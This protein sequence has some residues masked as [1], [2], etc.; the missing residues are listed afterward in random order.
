MCAVPAAEVAEL[1]ELSAA[2]DRL[3]ARGPARLGDAETVVE[4]HRQHARLDAVLAGVTAEF[5]ATE[6][7]ALDGARTPTMWLA[8]RCRI[9]KAVAKRR[10]R[11][12]SRIRKLEA[13]ARAWL[14]GDVTESHVSVID[15]IANRRTDDALARDEETLLEQAKGLRFDHF[16]KALNYWAQLADPDGTEDEAEAQRN[17]RDAYL[18][19]SFDGMFLGKLN[20]DPIS[21]AI[22]SNEWNRLVDELYES[23]HNAAK[24]R[25]GRNPGFHELA[26]DAAQRR[27]DALVE[28]AMRSAMVTGGARP[29]PLFTVLVDYETLSGRVCEL[30]QGVVV[31]PGTVVPWLEVADIERAVFGPARRVEIGQRARL[32]RGATRRS[33]ELRDGEC[34]HPFCDRPAQECEC[35]HIL[36]YAE[37]GETTQ[38]NGR[39]LCRP[40]NRMRNNL[41]P[42]RDD[43]NSAPKAGEP[44]KPRK[45]KKRDLGQTSQPEQ[46]PQP[47]WRRQQRPPPPTP[48]PSLPPAA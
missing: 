22:V 47:G 24:E 33:V 2:I 39:M 37:G 34:Q 17:R 32:F 12:G 28:M 48:P 35:D 31:S 29:R 3:V 36:P 18:V 23:D 21:G 42:R 27:A 13:W 16:A 19:P 45:Q 43:Q 14:A 30:A 41:R 7:W 9:P 15:S 1:D 26:R 38:E 46:R 20:L 44:K 40:H 4:L 6:A 25:L 10:I 5:A 11:L 8:V